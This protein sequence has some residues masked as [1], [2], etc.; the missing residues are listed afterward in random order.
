[1]KKLENIFQLESSSDIQSWHNFFDSFN[2]QSGYKNLQIYLDESFKG[3]S[4]SKYTIY[5][6]AIFDL[7]S[8]ELV[9]RFLVT[10]INNIVALLGA[11]QIG[12]DGEIAVEVKQKLEDE[13]GYLLE[14]IDGFFGSKSLIIDR[15]H[16]P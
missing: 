5:Y 16:I 12:L 8:K 3:K 13:F 6:P 1:M 10:E 4:I 2:S 9:L 7:K 15:I 14:L 11:S